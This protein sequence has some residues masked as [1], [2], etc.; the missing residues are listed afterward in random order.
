MQDGSV[1][2]NDSAFEWS[3]NLQGILGHGRSIAATALMPGN[4]TVTLSVTNSEGLSGTASMHI[5][6]IRPGQNKITS[7]E[8]PKTPHSPSS[9]R[10]C[11][12]IEMNIIIKRK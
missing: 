3:S 5:V 12:F 9:F 8:E 10:Q 11:H 2:L 4:H 1:G 6:I 7:T